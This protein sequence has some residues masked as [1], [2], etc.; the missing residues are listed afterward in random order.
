MFLLPDI[1]IFNMLFSLFIDIKSILRKNLSQLVSPLKRMTKSSKK[2]EET[3]KAPKAGEV[4]MLWQLV[5]GLLNSIPIVLM[6][7]CCFHIM[8]KDYVARGSNFWAKHKHWGFFFQHDVYE[9]VK[10]HDQD[11]I[12]DRKQ[13]ATCA[14]RHCA[15]FFNDF[16]FSDAETDMLLKYLEFSLFLLNFK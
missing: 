1:I 8:H 2:S 14:P 11:Y 13:F 15:R 12:Q 16:V 10:C 6:M 3:K 5:C 9:E 4:S 7:A